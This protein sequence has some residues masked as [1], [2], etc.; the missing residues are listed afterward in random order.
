[1]LRATLLTPI[2][3]VIFTLRTHTDPIV[4]N[5]VNEGIRKT[6]GERKEKKGRCETRHRSC[7]AHA[8]SLV[9][10]VS[11]GLERFGDSSS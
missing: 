10:G 1:M 9:D 5:T 11:Q 6:K 7:S 2:A 4:P 8:H 3:R